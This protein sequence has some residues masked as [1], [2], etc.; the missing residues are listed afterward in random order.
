MNKY[1]ISFLF[2]LTSTCYSQK[3]SFSQEI[4]FVTYLLEK[5]AYSD[6]IYVL[7]KLKKDSSDLNINQKDSLFYFLGW[8]NYKIK[9]TKTSELH[10]NKVTISSLYYL[11]SKFYE[12][13]E[14]IYDRNWQSAVNSLNEIQVP[15][16]LQK[17]KELRQYEL[18]G[19]AL[20]QRDTLNYKNYSKSFSYSYFSF[21]NEEKNLHTYV[22][23]IAKNKRKSALL[24]GTLSAVLP[25]AGKF[26]YGYK[27]QGAAVL[28][29][30]GILG[31]VA[32]ESY[33]KGG[34]LNPSFL[35]LGTA[36]TAF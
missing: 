18:A 30:L 31:V 5:E 25:G 21:S 6:A 29:Q 35:I 32:A 4:N 26:Y 27:A 17:L 34:P 22:D 8:S 19:I 9:N 36:F 20:L 7:N 24:A 33:I 10:F 23:K 1:I 11:K 12:S 16:S 2:F 15:D 13:Y 14:Y 28:F 3:F